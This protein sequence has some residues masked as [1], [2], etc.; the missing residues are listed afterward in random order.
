MVLVARALALSWAG[1]W[2][3]FFIAEAWAWHTPAHVV[4][5]WAGVGLLF[6][7]LALIPWRWEVTGGLVLLLVGLLIGVAYPIWAGPRLPLASRAITTVVLSGPPLVAGIV[8][9]IH[10][11]TSGPKGER[12]RLRRGPGCRRR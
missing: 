10:L 6:V 7:I 3:F 11:V 5:S 4:V 8:F 1:F 2:L 9:L 12:E